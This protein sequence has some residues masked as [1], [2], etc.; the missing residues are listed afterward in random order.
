MIEDKLREQV[1][2]DAGIGGSLSDRYYP[3]VLPQNPTYPALVS[4]VVSDV[5][6]GTLAGKSDVVRARIQLTVW[7]D[8]YVAAR[9]IIK[10]IRLLMDGTTGTWSGTRIGSVRVE[11]ELDA[12]GEETK[13]YGRQLDLMILYH[14]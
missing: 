10:A 6:E 5:Q 4:Q 3:M 14:E 7:A 8:T 12:F 9:S 13:I 2:A 1:L 11:N